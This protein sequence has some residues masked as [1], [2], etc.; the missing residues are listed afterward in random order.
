MNCVSFCGHGS[1]T[2]GAIAHKNNPNPAPVTEKTVGFRGHGTETTGAIGNKNNPTECPTCGGKINFKG[3]YDS[4]E[5]EGPSTL[6][7]IAGIA[8]VAAG[9]IGG[10]GYAHKAKA[11]DKLGE[12]WV[13]KTVGKLEP[14]GKKCHEWCTSVKNESTKLWTKV[15]DTFSSKK[16]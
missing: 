4:Y 16:S 11:F 10:L 6:G 5:K 12:G 7:V 14:A 15:K 3:G 8:L 13:K 9:I 1:E 2:T